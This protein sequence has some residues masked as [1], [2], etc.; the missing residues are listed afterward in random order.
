MTADD[1]EY[2]TDGHAKKS[3]RC[4]FCGKSKG[5]VQRLIAGPKGVYICD[6]CI[7]LC[8]EIIEEERE[9]LKYTTGQKT[10]SQP[11]TLDPN[12]TSQTLH[13]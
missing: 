13:N 8:N 2:R 4:S 12:A 10:S 9:L 11:E 7:S 3:Y 5:Q 6:E 1:E